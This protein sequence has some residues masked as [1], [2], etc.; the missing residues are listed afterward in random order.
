MSGC[1][2]F[3]PRAPRTRLACCVAPRATVTGRSSLRLR[4]VPPPALSVHTWP[5]A[6]EPD[7]LHALS[8]ALY[9][10]GPAVAILPRG[11]EHVL[12]AGAVQPAQ[13]LERDDVALVVPTSGSA[14]RP[15]GV[16]LPA[17]ALLASARL[18]HDR[19]GGTGQWLLALPPTHIAGVQVL[20][21]SIVAGEAPVV[22]ELPAGF[23]PAAFAERSRAL[24]GDRRYTALVPTQLRRLLDGGGKVL[25]ALRTYNAILVGGSAVPAELVTRARDEGVRIVTSYGMTETAGG[26]IYDGVPLAGVGI[27]VMTDGIIEVSGPTLAAG[28]RLDPAA[29]EAAFMGGR[30]RTSDRGRIDR[31]ARLVVLGRADDAI[32][33][34]GVV[35]DP[36][37]VETVLS[38]HPAIAAAAVVGRPDREWG[39]RVVAVVVPVASGE[40]PA[41][42]DVRRWVAD[43]LG[44]VQA[45][46]EVVVA[47]TLPTLP[48][49]KLDR[50]RVRET[51]RRG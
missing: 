27:E 24:T 8:H 51:V 16:L 35:V 47:T 50:S 3:A 49:G 41:L 11:P 34:G 45:P 28:Y 43:R 1:A 7:L 17:A 38:T 18:A 39:E 42:E 40:V 19:L 30:F 20:V 37:A 15:K 46:R 32:L 44:A 21:R 14:G 12:I 10:G 6:V 2:G 22:L 48:T 25:S 26:C 13:P 4:P 5:C 36:V 31:D 23:D 33:T 29:T 9:D